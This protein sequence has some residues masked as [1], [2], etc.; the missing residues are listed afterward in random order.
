[1]KKKC[2][3]AMTEPKR[4]PIELRSAP[5]ARKFKEDA[6]KTQ[7]PMEEIWGKTAKDPEKG[8]KKRKKNQLKNMF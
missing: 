3:S 8:K 2:E 6:K 5:I 4:A 1:M 7:Q